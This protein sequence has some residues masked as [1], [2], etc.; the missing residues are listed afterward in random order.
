LERPAAARVLHHAALGAGCDDRPTVTRRAP[1]A[2]FDLHNRRADPKANRAR[3]DSERSWNS[4]GRRLGPAARGAYPM[5]GCD[6][7][8]TPP[9]RPARPAVGGEEGA[10][11]AIALSP[12]VLPRRSRLWW[13]PP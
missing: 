13:P 10:W 1:D 6:G 5:F 8:P 11:P 9:A 7:E 2:S 3:P 4:L 12:L